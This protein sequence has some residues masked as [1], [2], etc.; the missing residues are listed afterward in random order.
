MY[1]SGL[2]DTLVTHANMKGFGLTPLFGDRRG[3]MPPQV[4]N[5]RNKTNVKLF[6]ICKLISFAFQ[7]FPLQQKW[8]LLLH[9][10]RLVNALNSMYKSGLVNM[11]VT[12]ASMKGFRR[13]PW[14]YASS[15]KNKTKQTKN[16][17]KCFP[18]ANGYILPFNF[19]HNS[20]D[21]F[22]SSI[23]L[24]QLMRL[25]LMYYM[26]AVIINYQACNVDARSHSE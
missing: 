22:Q 23:L 26:H 7:L 16:K 2:V 18:F 17:T 21:G 11:L 14:L 25:F 20:K 15:V 12:H 5:K 3:Y 10:A 19:C 24:V 1:R 9:L 13:P 4:K 6:S 8:L